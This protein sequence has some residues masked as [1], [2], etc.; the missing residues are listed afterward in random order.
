MTCVIP[1]C[2][3]LLC[4]SFYHF[5]AI[6]NVDSLRVLYQLLQSIEF[7]FHNLFVKILKTTSQTRGSSIHANL[8]YNYIKS[9]WNV[10]MKQN[11]YYDLRLI[12]YDLWYD[13]NRSMLK[14][15]CDDPSWLLLNLQFVFRLYM[16]SSS[17]EY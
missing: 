7:I 4:F 13:P 5:F 12:H 1:L 2:V 15:E 16:T 10:S 11:L 9:G 14:A 3:V 8:R 6:K 17:S